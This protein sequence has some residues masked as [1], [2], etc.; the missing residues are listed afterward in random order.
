M[1]QA[2]GITVFVSVC[3]ESIFK[4]C[5]KYDFAH[6][7]WEGTKSYAFF[8]VHSGPPHF[9]PAFLSWPPRVTG[10]TPAPGALLETLRLPGG[11]PL[12]EGE[13]MLARRGFRSLIFQVLAGTGG[14]MGKSLLER[15]VCL[16]T[17]KSSVWAG[18]R[19]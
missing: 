17:C 9:R 15:W 12:R 1:G 3:G 6:S 14:E 4:A 16:G 2:K 18:R 5:A 19:V 7:L 10:L 8:R 11:K 13:G